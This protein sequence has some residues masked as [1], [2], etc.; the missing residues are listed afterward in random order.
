MFML[1][2]TFTNFLIFLAQSEY[3]TFYDGQSNHSYFLNGYKP[4]K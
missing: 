4:D 1:I 3:D 2:I